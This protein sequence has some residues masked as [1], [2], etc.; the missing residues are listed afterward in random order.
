MGGGG[1]TYDYG[2]R[3]Y[4]PK[5]AKF[6]SVDPLTGSYPMLTP[7]QF[8]SDN[9]ILNIDLDGLEGVDYLKSQVISSD[10]K[11]MF[12]V[13]DKNNTAYYPIKANLVNGTMHIEH[14]GK[15]IQFNPSSAPTMLGLAVNPGFYYSLNIRSFSKSFLSFTDN[16]LPR[17]VTGATNLENQ[18]AG[19]GFINTFRHYAWQSLITMAL[20]KS[21]AQRSGDYHEKD[22]VFHP[23]QNGQFIK[24]N[25]ID[26]VNNE[27]ARD[28]GKG[29]DFKEVVKNTDN[30]AE[31]LNGL[32]QHLTN[33]VDGYKEDRSFDK[34]R[35]GEIKL[36]NG[37][38]KNFLK[39]YESTKRLDKIGAK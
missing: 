19:A 20:G 5:V 16:Q 21:A 35:S 9:P 29:F 28:Y 33:T 38:D 37:N 2:F 22:G 8:A 27:Y 4:N 11:A 39:A 36:F 17:L 18:Q 13:S 25:I 10:G 7:Y 15:N 31:Y 24:D 30:F 1:N 32:V 14:N 26:L 6:L 3:I 34:L 12:Q 23:S